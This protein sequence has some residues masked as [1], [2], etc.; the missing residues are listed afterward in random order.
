MEK[1]SLWNIPR[2]WS[3][4]KISNLGEVIAGG[5]P[6]SKE[7]TYWGGSISWISPADLTGYTKKRIDKG[8]K[9]ITESGLKNSS[10]KVM[11][12]GSV[13]FSSRAPIGYVAISSKPLATNQGF[14]SLI[15]APGIFNEFVYYYLKAS[16]S[17]AEERASGTTFLELSGKS[18]GLLP[19]PIPPLNEQKRIV[20]KI[21]ELFSELDSGI[22]ALKTAREQLKLYRQA[23]LKHAFEGKLTAKWREE[24]ADQLETPEQLLARIQQERQTRY[25]QQ[26]EEWQAA[27][28]T[29][30]A[31]GKEGKKPGKPGEPKS[32]ELLSSSEIQ[33]LFSPP[34]GWAF[35]RLSSFIERIDAGKSFK[36]DERE[37]CKNEIG[38]AKVSAVTWGEYNENE[39]K[40]CIDPSKVNPDYFIKVG[41]FILSRAN[42]ID[43]VG[44]CVIAKKVTKKIMLSDKT[45]RI[46]FKNINDWYVLQYLR[47]VYGRNEIMRRS[48]GNQES[49]RN[50]GQERI[51]NIIIPICSKNEML[52]VV[53]IMNE[54]LEICSI[55]SN[56]IGLQIQ[57]AE[58]LRHS[59]LKKAFSGKLVPQDP[60]DEPASELLARIQAE[61]AAATAQQKTVA[62]KTARK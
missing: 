15:P 12:A 62:K 31:N 59:I 28:K 18:F 9:S 56:D 23:V 40:T 22:T 26:L 52:K 24:N 8:N 37:P 43:L 16:K 39:S 32:I 61:K 2:K 41:D 5:T 58:T 19:I 7:P 42:T 53:Q 57:K 54:K 25:Q 35:F 38:V 48:T 30:K 21:E 11:P 50:I 51:R 49:M 1:E 55:L 45:L 27:V 29:W 3:W 14:K 33:K 44:A 10:A 46:V 34:Q 20:A 4:S 47:S 13:H 36:C 6:S 60:N 17:L